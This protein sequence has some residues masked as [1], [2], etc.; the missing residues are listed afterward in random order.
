MKLQEQV[1][2]W[3]LFDLFTTPRGRAFV[4]SQAADA[5]CGG[6][7]RIFDVL[8]DRIDDPEL[9]ALVRRHRDDE[10][11]HARLFADC[12]ARQG[13]K[14]PVVPASLRMLDPV[15]RYVGEARGGGRFFDVAV[16]DDRYV[17]DAYLVLQVLEERAAQQLWLLTRALRPFDPRSAAIVFEIAT[18][19]RRHL[20][21]CQAISR[22]YAPDAGLRTARLGSFREAEARAFREHTRLSLEFLAAEGFMGSRAKS[23]FWRGV[24]TATAFV[25]LPWTEQGRA[26]PDARLRAA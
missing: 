2:Q 8:L 10:A 17:A 3:F 6:E 11:R 12:A 22:R 15:D 9:A 25:E 14:T 16:A 5:K 19:E 4:L 26:T 21:D 24:G 18:E 23:L 13:A 20:R 7:H 1:H